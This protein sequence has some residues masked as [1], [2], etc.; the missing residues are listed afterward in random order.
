MSKLGFPN[1]PCAYNTIF[2]NKFFVKATLNVFINYVMKMMKMVFWG[3]G[4]A[5]ILYSEQQC[6]NW[7]VHKPWCLSENSQIKQLVK[8]KIEHPGNQFSEQFQTCTMLYGPNNKHT[9]VQCI[10]YDLLVCHNQKMSA[11]I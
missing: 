11:R 3:F 5:H 1:E 10:R 7:Q 8:L 2:E 9:I 4:R 6:A